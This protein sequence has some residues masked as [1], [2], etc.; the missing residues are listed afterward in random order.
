VSAP[1]FVR[2]VG[3]W[4]PEAPTLA[5]FLAGER[6]AAPMRPAAELLPPRMRGRASP[7]TAMLAN[8]VEQATR[9]AGVD[10]AELP[11]VFGSAYGEMQTTLCLLQQLWAAESLSP[12][13]FQASVHN[14]AAAQLSIALGNRSFSTSLA[15]GHDTLA[16]VLLEASAWLARH[17]GLLLVACGDE[18]PSEALQPGLSYSPLA[19]AFVLDNVCGRGLARIESI[20][21]DEQAVSNERPSDNPLR[22]ALT[23]AAAVFAGERTRLRVNEGTALGY[24]IVVDARPT[25]NAVE[26]DSQ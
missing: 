2:G 13:K 24:H 16:A 6:S 22:P 17:P 9:S 3:V 5:Q 19:A 8:V 20:S 26:L 15:A 21:L 25:D 23:L 11:S 7:L 4:T 10:P 1:I 12:A 18:A 14:T